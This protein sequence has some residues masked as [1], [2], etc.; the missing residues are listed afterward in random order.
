MIA[1]AWFVLILYLLF[2][3]MKLTSWSIGRCVAVG[4]VCLVACDGGQFDGSAAP[5]PP[6]VS[7]SGGNRVDVNAMLRQELRREPTVTERAF[8]TSELAHRTEVQ[9]R[10]YARL[11]ADTFRD[12]YRR[13]P[14][15]KELAR[16]TERLDHG[17]LL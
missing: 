2:I 15:R 12:V 10:D 7:S 11:I 4:V 8:W 17:A 13:P 6:A 14:T 3:I 9:V 16:F 1:I 5:G